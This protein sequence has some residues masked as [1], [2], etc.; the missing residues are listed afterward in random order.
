MID[1]TDISWRITKVDQKEYSESIK[2]TQK[3]NKIEVYIKEKGKYKIT[4]IAES[5][6]GNIYYCSDIY[7]IEKLEYEWPDFSEIKTKN[8]PKL[9]IEHQFL[10]TS[11]RDVY[12][13]EESIKKEVKFN[14]KIEDIDPQTIKSYVIG[15]ENGI[16]HY[17]Q[18][19]YPLSVKDIKKTKIKDH[20]YLIE[21]EWEESY[22]APLELYYEYRKDGKYTVSYHVNTVDGKEFKL[23][24]EIHIEGLNQKNI[25]IKNAGDI[26]SFGAYTV[27]YI[28][29]MKKIAW[30]ELGE[31]NDYPESITIIGRNG[32]FHAEYLEREKKCEADN[33]YCWYLGKYTLKQNSSL[34][35]STDFEVLAIGGKITA[36]DIGGNYILEELDNY[37]TLFSNKS[38]QYLRWTK[39]KKEGTVFLEEKTKS[40]WSSVTSNKKNIEQCTLKGNKQF[41]TIQHDS[42]GEI[43]FDRDGNKIVYSSND[44]YGDHTEVSINFHFKINNIKYYWST[45]TIKGGPAEYLLVFAGDEWHRI[46][47]IKTPDYIY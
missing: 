23:S 2:K 13:R 34:F 14:F 9:T 43:L 17:P 21:I 45:I 20:S 46:R 5:K 39:N 35:Q 44:G 41:V 24:K 38:N 30:I 40:G 29:I 25:E 8:S 26:K 7:N 12:N 32:Y 37:K 1:F 10:D 22:K 28:D 36:T 18:D 47:L 27:L 3:G 6:N 4:S 33:S 31:E 15:F 11:R 16:N 19:Y 42:F